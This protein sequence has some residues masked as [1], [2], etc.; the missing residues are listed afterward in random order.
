MILLLLG[1][2]L[3][4]YM[5]VINTIYAALAFVGLFMLPLSLYWDFHREMTFKE[6]LIYRKYAKVYKTGV[7]KYAKV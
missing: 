7:K 2:S 4:T 6:E 5:L 3:F 1:I